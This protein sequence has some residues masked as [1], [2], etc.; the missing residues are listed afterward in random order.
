MRRIFTILLALIIISCGSD[1]N[2]YTLSG[3]ALGF[4]D[5]TQILVNQIQDNNQ[6]KVID[7]LIITNGSFSGS[8]AKSEDLSIHFLKVGSINNNILF[9]PENQN[10]NAVIYKDSIDASHVL[11]SP[12]NDSYDN[13]NKT[14]RH[15][16]NRK[17]NNI[18]RNRKARQ[19]QDGQLVSNIRQENSALLNEEKMFK[20][21]FVHENPNSLFTVMLLSEMLNR[22]EVSSAQVSAIL[23]TLSPKVASSSSVQTLSNALESLKKADVGALAP[24]FTAPTPD[25]TML[26]LD[27]ALGEYT[28]IDFWASWC[29]PCRREN[30]NL[31]NLYEKYHE[32][33]LNIIG[34]SLDKTSARWLKAIEMDNLQWQQVSNLKSWKEPVALDYNV[35]SIPA[36]FLL[37]KDGKIIAKNLRGPA[38]EQK[39]ASL[40]D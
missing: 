29:K 32:K 27:D 1:S 21:A 35:R 39:I 5:G 6:P 28:I 17:K 3:K 4:I 18:E 24:K 15:I 31:V 11:G 14:I 22:K 38:L 9:F 23:K 12:Q 19:E 20:N 26:S 7:T 40:L 33:G 13:F 2:N 30:P 37:D 10:L 34:V 25:G 16:N 36:A 8:Y